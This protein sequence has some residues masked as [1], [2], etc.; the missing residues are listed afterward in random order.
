[1]KNSFLESLKA[2]QVSKQYA[3]QINGGE[4][5]IDAC[6]GC[7]LTAIRDGNYFLIPQCIEVVC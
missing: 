4:Q 3:K 6:E 2:Q 7:I 1:M 5:L